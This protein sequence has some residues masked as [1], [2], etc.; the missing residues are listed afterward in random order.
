MYALNLLQYIV[1]LILLITYVRMSLYILADIHKLIYSLTHSLACSL[2]F[3]SLSLFLY[4]QVSPINRNDDGGGGVGGSDDGGNDDSNRTSHG[5]ADEIGWRRAAVFFLQCHPATIFLTS[6]Q[7]IPVEIFCLY[8]YDCLTFF[9][10]PYRIMR[11]NTKHSVY[12]IRFALLSLLHAFKNS[13][14]HARSSARIHFDEKRK[15]EKTATNVQGKWTREWVHT[16]PHLYVYIDIYVRTYVYIPVAPTIHN[17]HG[18]SLSL[19]VFFSFVRSFILLSSLS[20]FFA[21]SRSIHTGYDLL[22]AFHVSNEFHVCEWHTQMIP[23]ICIHTH[24]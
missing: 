6:F 17:I 12:V 11:K 20:S 21:Q 9:G 13:H 19:Y 23:D 2:S 8:L 22:H 4:P 10:S 5:S 7:F 15:T 3:F 16:S 1:H 18:L 14:I 24:T